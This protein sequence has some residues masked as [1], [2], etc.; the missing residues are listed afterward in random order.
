[1]STLC[2]MKFCSCPHAL[3]ALLESKVTI[4]EATGDLYWGMGLSV[5]QMQECLP[6]YWPGQNKMGHILI[7]LH[8]MFQKENHLK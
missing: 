7:G 6:E 1:M 4:A 8:S 3:Q 5:A 2:A